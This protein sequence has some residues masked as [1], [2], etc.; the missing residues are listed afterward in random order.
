[1]PRSSSPRAAEAVHPLVIG[2]L[3][4]LV[5]ALVLVAFD[6]PPQRPARP[7]AVKTAGPHFLRNRSVLLF[8]P[9]ML[10]K[11]YRESHG[12]EST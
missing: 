4:M 11:A 9:E 10:S 3:I 5:S 6:K 2:A 7:V 1:M 8:T 12:N